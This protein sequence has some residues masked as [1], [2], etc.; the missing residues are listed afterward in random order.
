MASGKDHLL[1][2]NAF[3]NFNELILDQVS[4]RQ[5]LN[6]LNLLSPPLRPFR[7]ASMFE[8]L[9]LE[10]E[11]S[12]KR[13]SVFLF[14]YGNPAW[15]TARA[16][17]SGNFFACAGYEILDQPA[18]DSLEEGIKAAKKAHPDL[19]VLCSP[20]EI[21]PTIA[22]LV[23]EALGTMLFLWWPGIPPNL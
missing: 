11:R 7:I 15:A 1:G 23:S 20:D 19:I 21:Y 12:G 2:T 14:K 3:P 5:S 13:P 6:H 22:P 8:D 17:F 16:T 9:R 10:T 4:R 18:F